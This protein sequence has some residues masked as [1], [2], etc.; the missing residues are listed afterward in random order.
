MAKAS[1]EA[2]VLLFFRGFL[3]GGSFSGH[4]GLAGENEL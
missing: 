3:L 2:I 1:D 4:G